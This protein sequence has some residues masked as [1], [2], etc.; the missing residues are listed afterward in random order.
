ML[1]SGVQVLPG[2]HTVGVMAEVVVPRVMFT[3][4]GAIIATI[5]V[6]I[7][8]VIALRVTTMVT[9]LIMAALR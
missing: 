5:E 6:A 4:V 9:G 3:E 2:L 7:V 8:G 1:V